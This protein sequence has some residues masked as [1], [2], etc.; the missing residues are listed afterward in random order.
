MGQNVF[1]HVDDLNEF[2]QACSIVMNENSKL[3]IQT[4]QCDMLQNNQFDT[5]YHEHLSFFTANS[6]SVILSKNG[7]GLLSITKAPIHG[8]SYFFEIKKGVQNS[9][10]ANTFI[11]EEN[12]LFT[13]EFFDNY[14]N[15]CNKI[16]TDLSVKIDDYRKENMTVI[17]YGAAAKGNTLLNWGKIKL[18]YIVDDSPNKWNLLT[19]GTNIK[20]LP[21]TVLEEYPDNLV[22]IVLAWNFYNEIVENITKIR[23]GKKTVFYS[24]YSS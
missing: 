24:I 7:F 13:P 6:M 5:I 10:S 19:P 8:N 9:D 4:S 20:I 2:L 12:D 16:I 17:G 22:I 14:V 11:K 18:D 3:Y 21:P 1:A 23:K 15:N